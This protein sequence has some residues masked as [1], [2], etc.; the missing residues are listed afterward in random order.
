MQ[1]IQTKTY[2]FT[3]FATLALFVVAFAISA[4]ITQKKTDELKADEDKISI[5]ILSLETQYD[6]LKDS[7]CKAFNRDTL[8]GELDNLASKL[9]FMEGQV[10]DDNPEVFRLKRYYSLLEIKDYLLTKKMS[11]QCHLDTVFILY[12]YAIKDCPEC[13]TQEYLLRAIRD[14]YPQTETYSFDYALDLPAVRTLIT[15]HNIPPKPPVIDINGKA[16]ASFDSLES[17]DSI[18]K[19]YI[20]TATSTPSAAST[21]PTKNTKKITH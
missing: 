20:K 18:I 10:G 15:L 12:F 14:E 19:P 7:S 4:Y 1:P 9:Q 16:Y 5:N 2:F 6:L 13:Q 17:L 3:L 11:E 8:R 21:T